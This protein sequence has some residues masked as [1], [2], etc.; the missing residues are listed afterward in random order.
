MS[1]F[2]RRL[3]SSTY[4]LL[5]SFERRQQ[6]LANLVEAMRS[7]KLDPTKLKVRQLALD[8]LSGTRDTFEEKTADE[9]EA[10]NEQEEN[11]VIEDQ[12]LEGIVATTLAELEVEL[13]Q[14]EYLRD[15][16]RKVHTAGG[17]SKFE[18]L[19]EILLDPR[20]KQEKII[21]FTEHR[22]TLE[23]L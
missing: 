21:I 22:D 4:A 23:L 17:E 5:R 2:Q 6:K 14:V 3:I 16:A 15:L 1:V 10:M 8:K 18:K 11:E 9:E 7:G 20:Y 13:Q 19:R 12:I